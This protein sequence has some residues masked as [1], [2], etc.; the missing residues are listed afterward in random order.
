[1]GKSEPK[2]QSKGT[3]GTGEEA[4]Y[5]TKGYPQGFQRRTSW[6]RFSRTSR[7]SPM[8]MVREGI[9]DG[10]DLVCKSPEMSEHGVGAAGSPK[11][12]EPQL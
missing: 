5:M 1:M 11:W 2:T 6:S 12:L 8:D 10:G 9:P 7:N 4:S 3:P